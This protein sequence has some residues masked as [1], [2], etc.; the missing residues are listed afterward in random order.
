MRNIRIVYLSCIN[1]VMST[2]SSSDSRC[3]GTLV[4]K[5]IVYGNTAVYF[6]KK[7]E[8]D[9]HTHQWTVF[10]K[11]YHYEDASKWIRK[12]QFKLH[13][14]YANSTRSKNINIFISN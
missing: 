8:E 12:V 7:R 6:G 9:G 4:V 2:E 14:S 1:Y 11:P 10:V 5:P 13:D 3:K